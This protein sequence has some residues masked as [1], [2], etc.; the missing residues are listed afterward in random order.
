MQQQAHSDSCAK[1]SCAAGAMLHV[2][3]T[4]GRADQAVQLLLQAWRSPATSMQ[5]QAPAACLCRLGSRTA[6]LHLADGSMLPMAA[7][8]TFMAWLF[9]FLLARIRSASC[10]S[11]VN[12]SYSSTTRAGW[13]LLSLFLQLSVTAARFSLMYLKSRLALKAGTGTGSAATAAAAGAAA[14]GWATSRLHALW[15][16]LKQRAGCASKRWLPDNVWS[17]ILA[18]CVRGPLQLEHQSA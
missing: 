2:E 6:A 5:Q 7:L 8:R 1:G 18:M 4:S 15:N 12:S 3:Q 17:S 14:R 11:C 16:G 9:S 13:A 10:L